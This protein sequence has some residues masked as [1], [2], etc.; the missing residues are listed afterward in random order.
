MEGKNNTLLEK[1]KE[2]VIARLELLTP[3]IHFAS[4]IY[5]NLKY[6]VCLGDGSVCL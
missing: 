4:A 1:E 2:L 6:Q 5:H 3:N